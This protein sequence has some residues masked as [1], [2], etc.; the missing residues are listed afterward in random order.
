VP[1]NHHAVVWQAANRL[2]PYNGSLVL[3]FMENLDTSP[4]VTDTDTIPVFSLT[5]LMPYLKEF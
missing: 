4:T 2:L 3:F 1:Q 5:T